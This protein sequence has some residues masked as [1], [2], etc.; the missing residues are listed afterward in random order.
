MNINELLQLIDSAQDEN[1]QVFIND[2]GYELIDFTLNEYYT[3]IKE[4]RTLKNTLSQ[5]ISSFLFDD[6]SIIIEL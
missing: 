6:N 5:K 1:T 2:N 3:N 4:S